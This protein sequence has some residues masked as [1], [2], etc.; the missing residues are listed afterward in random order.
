MGSSYLP[1]DMIAAFLYAQLEH[2]A[3]INAKRMNIW[4]KYNE[5]FKQYEDKGYI[6]RPL[7]SSEAEHNAHMYYIIFNSLKER[8]DF[9]NYLKENGVLSVFHYIPLHSAPAGKKYGRYVGSMSVTDKISDTLT[10]LPLFCNLSEDE[11]NRIFDV[12]EKYFDNI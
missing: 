2:V 6:K 3:E 5:F 9:I 11:L 1:S 4:N 12:I 7:I 8:T 10:R